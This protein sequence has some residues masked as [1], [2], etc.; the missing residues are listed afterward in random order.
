MRVTQAGQ[1]ALILANLGDLNERLLNLR[2]QASSGYRM[3]D[4]SEDPASYGQILSLK[5]QEAVVTAHGEVSSRLSGRLAYYDTVLGQLSDNVRN[6]RTL[7]QQGASSGTD[8]T[9]LP[10]LAT[11]VNQVLDTVLGI[12]NDQNEGRYIFAGAKVDSP[13]YVATRLGDQVTGVTY[14]GDD[15][16][17]DV[18]LDNGQS[19]KFSV[20]GSEVFG[21]DPADP[22]SVIG[23]LIQLRDALQAG[24]QAAATASMT[25]LDNV[26]SKVLAVRGEVGAREQHLASLDLLRNN[27][28]LQLQ[29]QRDSVQNVDLPTTVSQLMQEQT[30]W[31]SALQVA[32]RVDQYNLLN[33][34]R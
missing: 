33:M 10:L 2:M 1:Q 16:P 30:V 8:P 15:R 4:G 19:M 23:S 13:P 18:T 12:A 27:V 29:K 28:I 7:A 26:Y 32:S 11:Q 21:A 22:N 6:A 25:V 5:S 31:Q 20:S 3:Q 17:Q 14:Q 34:L 24:D 9:N